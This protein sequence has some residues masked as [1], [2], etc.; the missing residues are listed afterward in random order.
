[1][2]KKVGASFTLTCLPG[3]THAGASTEAMCTSVPSSRTRRLRICDR[4]RAANQPCATPPVGYPVK[5]GVH[6]IVKI[7]VGVK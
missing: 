1:M 2:P 5:I 6:A 7:A 3:L 4:Y